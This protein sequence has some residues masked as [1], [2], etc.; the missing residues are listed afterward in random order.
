MPEAKG[1]SSERKKCE[2]CGRPVPLEPSPEDAAWLMEKASLGLRMIRWL[3]QSRAI[4]DLDA[5][6]QL[7]SFDC[8]E[9]LILDFVRKE[10]W[11][12]AQHR[13]DRNKEKG[14]ERA[15]S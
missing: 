9:R 4:W 6:Y 5:F 15:H 10:K 13:A 12:A 11:R 8:A 7:C 2:Y 14:R 3:P 1:K